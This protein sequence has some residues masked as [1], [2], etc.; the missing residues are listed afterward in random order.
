VTAG[1]SVAVG[2]C[3]PTHP[4]GRPDS[5]RRPRRRRR[6]RR[7]P[8]PPLTPGPRGRRDVHGGGP[9]VEVLE[10]GGGVRAAAPWPGFRS[11]PPPR[12]RGRSVEGRS[13]R[14]PDL[15]SF[16][17]HG[18]RPIQAD[19]SPSPNQVNS[20]SCP[21]GAS[22]GSWARLPVSEAHAPAEAVIQSAVAS[23][24]SVHR[25]TLPPSPLIQKAHHTPHRVL[26]F[27]PDVQ[28]VWGSPSVL[29]LGDLN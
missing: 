21:L 7:G 1:W 14:S 13:L 5:D 11:P 4:L 6:R 20:K 15:F 17:Y 19:S 9:G 12:D 26:E 27:A 24:H 8:P 18:Q 23:V 29:P 16:P 3:T 25:G 10:P 2:V 22:V 28:Q